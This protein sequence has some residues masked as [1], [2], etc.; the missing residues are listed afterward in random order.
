[1]ATTELTL[2]KLTTRLIYGLVGGFVIGFVLAMMVWLFC[3]PLAAGRTFG[4]FPIFM[5]VLGGVWG[6]GLLDPYLCPR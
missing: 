6:L 3:N 2:P 5:T 4:L 1:M